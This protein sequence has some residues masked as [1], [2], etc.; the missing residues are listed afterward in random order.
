[1]RYS[2][3]TAIFL[4]SAAG[5]LTCSSITTASHADEFDPLRHQIEDLVAQRNLPSV[6]VAI[7]K[8]EDII[9]VE[10][11]GYANLETGLRATPET[12]YSLASIS[13]VFTGMSAVILEE[14]GHLDLNSPANQYLGADKLK[15]RIGDVSDITVRRLLNHTSGLSTYFNFFYEDRDIP[16]LSMDETIGRYGEALTSPGEI[17]SYSNLG[18]GVLEYIIERQSGLTYSEFLQKEIFTPLGMTRSTVNR[19]KDLGDNV[20]VRYDHSGEPVPFYDFNHR[21]ASAVYASVDDLVRFGMFFIGEL[22][23][24]PQVISKD[25]LQRMVTEID[26]AAKQSPYGLGI[27]AVELN[28]TLSYVHAGGMPGVSTYLVIIPEY[29]AVVV[30]LTN[31]SA[32]GAYEA[33]TEI[34][35][36][37]IALVSET[38][39]KIK[40]DEAIF[41]AWRGSIVTYEETVPVD[42]E[43]S[44]D[45]AV[46]VKIGT[47]EKKRA[48]IVGDDNGFYSVMVRDARTPIA[49]VSSYSHNLIFKLKG[50]DGV[51]NGPATVLPRLTNDRTEAGISFWT[52]FS[53]VRTKKM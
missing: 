31:S 6:S 9:F 49:D 4:F 42:I 17:F 32:Y 16:R 15:A 5:A 25:G 20:A 2:I 39:D 23:D 51:L 13:K 40:V 41:G 48:R 43:F 36:Q 29:E 10:S 53:K 37:A 7:A 27:G 1:M 14:R 22:P 12:S 45:A 35:D 52:E 33:L 18:Y 47:Q 50:R 3:K 46:W 11:F 24:A 26:P 34:R 38:E 30:A 21:G 19:D 44:Y 8:G 28:G